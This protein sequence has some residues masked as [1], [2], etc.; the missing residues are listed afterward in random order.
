MANKNE[1]MDATVPLPYVRKA[2]GTSETT[3]FMFDR[4]KETEKT[5]IR[6]DEK[7][8]QK[9]KQIEKVTT[10]IP[11]KVT[12]KCYGASAGEDRESFFEAFDWLQ[13]ALEPEWTEAA[14]AK[15]RDAT[16]LF[17]ALDEVL[18]GV[19]NSDWRVILGTETVRTWSMFKEKV[20]KYICTKVLP[21]NA[22]DEQV[23]YLRE[24]SKPMSL[25]ATE[26]NDRL[27]TLSRYLP[28]F[29]ESVD[30]LKV[31]YPSATFTDWWKLGTLSEAERRRII[32]HKAPT[33]WFNKLDDVDVGHQIMH[34]DKP[35]R[36]VNYFSRLEA[37]EKANALKEKARKERNQHRQRQELTGSSRRQNER[38]NDRRYRN[39][40]RSDQAGRQSYSY[41]NNNNNNRGNRYRDRGPRREQSQHA[42]GQRNER[43]AWKEQIKG[44]DRPARRDEHHYQEEE[45]EQH[46]ID[47]WNDQFHMNTSEDDDLNQDNMHDT[48][49]QNHEAYYD[50]G[51]EDSRDSE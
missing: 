44:R 25:S 28:Y 20:S 45:E 36:I 31:E 51:S 9:E 15:E 49:S 16:V 39:D 17:D 46:L 32:L 4:E 7:G 6:Y 23:L 12:L 41:S 40:R 37:R 2:K 48:A 5:I 24:R 27:E 14:K 42:G 50:S 21:P 13:K 1:T 35:D 8:V 10:N 26:W 33:P 3:K 18:I 22:Y 47:T 19:A 34:E 11:V 30:S 29:F 43:P 38:S